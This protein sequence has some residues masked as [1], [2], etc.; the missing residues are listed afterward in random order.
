MKI[1]F[2]DH[3]AIRVKDLNYSANWYN[4]VLGLEI[5]K[6][7]E[8]GEFP[9][10]LFAGKSG[11]ALFPAKSESNQK[12]SIDH[13]AFNVDYSDFENFKA[14]LNSLEIAFVEK[15]HHYFL[16]IYFND[17]D[18]HEVELTTLKPDFSNFYPSEST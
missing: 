17:P 6:T 12:R 9:I 4:R 14:H 16:S 13:F 2:L 10:F 3:V 1:N 8:W 18:G 5:V 7:T 11:I 15:D